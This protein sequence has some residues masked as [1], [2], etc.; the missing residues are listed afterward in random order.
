MISDPTP[1]PH[2]KHFYDLLNYIHGHKAEWD[3]LTDNG[4]LFRKFLPGYGSNDS[5]PPNFQFPNNPRNNEDSFSNT[6]CEEI[7][8]LIKDQGSGSNLTPYAPTIPEGTHVPHIYNQGTYLEIPKQSPKQGARYNFWS[9]DLK[10][11]IS[12]INNQSEIL[13]N[14]YLRSQDN[15]KTRNEPLGENGCSCTEIQT[16]LNKQTLD[17]KRHL[18]EDRKS[19]RNDNLEIIR[20]LKDLNNKE[21]LQSQLELLEDNQSRMLSRLDEING[22]RIREIQQNIELILKNQGKQQSL[23]N[24][25]RI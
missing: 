2:K 6:C 17:I 4:N 8:R 20:R 7:K 23:I 1:W 19:I 22:E 15:Q 25:K 10:G 18:E 11:I 9:N 21:G 13:G 16:K 12:I 5:Y 24:F 14:I 3:F